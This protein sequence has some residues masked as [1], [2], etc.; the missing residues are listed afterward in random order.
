MLAWATIFPDA[1]HFCSGDKGGRNRVAPLVPESAAG[2]GV[3]PVRPPRYG[4][5]S[6]VRH[7][8]LQFSSWR[9]VLRK[10][11]AHPSPFRDSGDKA[12]LEPA[13]GI[14]D[15]VFPAFAMSLT[16]LSIGP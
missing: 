5:C 7:S 3:E 8:P 2:T 16:C 9:Q 10:H 14:T 4:G 1:R 11:L 13:P 12:G 15:V 6:F